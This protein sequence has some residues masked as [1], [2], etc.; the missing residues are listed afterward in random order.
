MYA[1]ASS[2]YVFLGLYHYRNTVGKK[3]TEREK[4]LNIGFHGGVLLTEA[5]H[6]GYD[7][8]QIACNEGYFVN[9]LE[10]LNNKFF[11]KLIV[12]NLKT[13]KFNSNYIID[14]DTAQSSANN[15]F[16]FIAKFMKVKKVDLYGI[17]IYKKNIKYVSIIYVQKIF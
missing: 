2:P 17:G 1:V 11:G 14:L 5:L 10:Y 13:S 7:V 9:I 4:I 3:V 15:C 12:Y 6:L 16:E 8:A